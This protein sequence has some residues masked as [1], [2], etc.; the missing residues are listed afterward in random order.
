MSVELEQVKGQLVIAGK[1]DPSPQ[2]LKLKQEMAAIKVLPE[3]VQ[4]AC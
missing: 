2:I 1:Q 3:E 4:H